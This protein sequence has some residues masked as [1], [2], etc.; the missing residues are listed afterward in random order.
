MHTYTTL[1]LNVLNQLQA[2]LCGIKFIKQHF[3]LLHV[4]ATQLLDHLQHDF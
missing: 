2:I 1:S 3:L 4:F